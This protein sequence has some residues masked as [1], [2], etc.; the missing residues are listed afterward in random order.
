MRRI[1]KLYLVHSEG[2]LPNSGR[3]SAE[4]ILF[5]GMG[6]HSVQWYGVVGTKET[7]YYGLIV[8]VYLKCKNKILYAQESKH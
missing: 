2:K 5:L 7:F 1:V 4:E 6:I 8:N 3:P